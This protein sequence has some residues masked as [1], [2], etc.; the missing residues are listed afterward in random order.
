MLLN[1]GFRTNMFVQDFF[2]SLKRIAM[3]KIFT[4]FLICI[5]CLSF[6]SCEREILP[7]K[8]LVYFHIH[9][10]GDPFVTSVTLDK[11]AESSFF[12]QFKLV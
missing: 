12:V 10:T 6:M 9:V 11:P 2:S 4:L 8:E 7:P 5:A 1:R 3:R